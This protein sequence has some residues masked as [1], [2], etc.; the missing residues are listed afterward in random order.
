MSVKNDRYYMQVAMGL[1]EKGCPDTWPN[2]MVGAVVVKKTAIVGK[3]WHHCCGGPHAEVYALQKAGKQAMGS[4]LYLNLE[5]CSHHGKTPPCAE[6]V[7]KAGIERVVC[8]MRDPN[9][10]V[11]GRGFARL[12]RA[13]IVVDVGLMKAEAE[14]LNRVFVKL[15]ATD[16]PYVVNKVALSMDGKIASYSGKSRWIS[17]LEARKYAHQLRYRSD[18]IVVGAQTVFQDNPE[19]NIRLVSNLRQRQ[20]LR[21][22]LEGK[23]R[24][25]LSLRMMKT[26]QEQN[27]VIASTHAPRPAKQ[28]PKGVVHWQFAGKDNHVPIRP[29]LR[30]LRKNGVNSVLVEGGA[31]IHAAFLG[32]DGSNGPIY[33]DEL[34][35]VLAPKIIGGKDA[36]GPIGGKGVSDP[37]FAIMLKD[38][39]LSSLGSDMLVK[40]RPYKLKSRRMKRQ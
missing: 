19:L 31:D 39:Q 26:S 33:S 24:I 8:A 32:L 1:A 3:G 37:N 17:G 21:V 23:R 12:R 2:P 18:A 4:T 14:E 22:L 35:M 40:A 38:M 16:I 7:V 25:P 20:P 36:L 5:P 28:Y 15:I 10:K 13:G 30:C 29:L 6:A 34:H 27:I 11:A 9:P